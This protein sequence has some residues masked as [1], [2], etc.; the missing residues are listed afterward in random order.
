MKSRVYKRETL[1]HDTPKKK[2]NEQNRKRPQ[3]INFH[4]S[5]LEK[6]LIERRIELSGLSRREFFLQ[7]CLLQKILVRGNSQTFTVIKER[8]TELAQRLRREDLE[9]LN[10]E[11]AISLKTIVEIIESKFRKG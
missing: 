2:K 8:L 1:P 6:R 9:R 7:S 11:E 5:E 10:D 3:C 4:V